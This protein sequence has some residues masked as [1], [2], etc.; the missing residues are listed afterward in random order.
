VGLAAVLIWQATVAGGQLEAARL[1]R[2]AEAVSLAQASSGR[3]VPALVA[4]TIRNL[5]RAAELD[6]LDPGIP[7][8]LGSQYLLLD[9]PQEAIAAYEEAMALEPRPEFYLNLGRALRRAGDEEA[10]EEAFETAVVLDWRLRKHV[11]P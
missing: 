10:A 2:Q 1:R 3:L 5:R 9:R 11:P 8:L 6:P 4:E 7:M